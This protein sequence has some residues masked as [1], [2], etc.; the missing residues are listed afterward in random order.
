MMDLAGVSGPQSNAETATKEEIADCN[1]YAAKN[2]RIKAYWADGMSGQKSEP[3][4]FDTPK[5]ASPPLAQ[6]PSRLAVEQ[7]KTYS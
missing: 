3:I 5:A 2:P 1:Q 7:R 6:Q 4:K